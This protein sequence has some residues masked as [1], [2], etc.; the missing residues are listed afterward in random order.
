LSEI[1]PSARFALFEAL[2]R[3]E[4]LG[5]ALEHAQALEPEFD[6]GSA[7]RHLIELKILTSLRL[8]S[9]TD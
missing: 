5:A 8:P 9:S 4:N 1:V 3:G 7:L 6:F 2:G